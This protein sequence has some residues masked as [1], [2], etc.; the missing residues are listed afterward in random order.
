MHLH[1][2][3]ILSNSVEIPQPIHTWQNRLPTRKKVDWNPNITKKEP[4]V[5]EIL[6]SQ[7]HNIKSYPQVWSERDCDAQTRLIPANKP[8]ATKLFNSKLIASLNAFESK[9]ALDVID[10]IILWE[11]GS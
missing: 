1:H 9:A 8:K 3:I 4:Y 10:G 11:C 5:A 2:I 7:G 6:T